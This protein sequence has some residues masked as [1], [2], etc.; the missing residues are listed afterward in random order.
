[1]NAIRIPPLREFALFSASTATDACH[2]R[3]G[4][5]LPNANAMHTSPS[6]AELALIAKGIKAIAHPL[7]LG[8]VCLLADGE[9]SV[10]DICD[11][12]G[13][14]QPNIS[15]HLT[16]LA[17]RK[18]LNARKDANRVLYSVANPKLA[19]VVALLREIYC[20]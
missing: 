12:L 13:T 2:A 16:R 6:E 9:L 18:L 1:M 19:A 17:D 4:S 10:G 7:R 11:A 8:A 15:H 20:P 14:S 3:Q 5:H